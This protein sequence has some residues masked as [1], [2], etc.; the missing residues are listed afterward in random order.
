LRPLAETAQARNPDSCS[1]TARI[2]FGST[3]CAFA[4]P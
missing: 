4:A 2:S 1:I 3:D